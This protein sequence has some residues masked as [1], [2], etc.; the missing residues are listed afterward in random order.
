M[1]TTAIITQNRHDMA[2]IKSISMGKIL[3]KEPAAL[4]D[5]LEAARLPGFFCID[6]DGESTRGLVDDVPE[7]F[8]LVKEYFCQSEP[9]KMKNFNPNY[10]RGYKKY[11]DHESFEIALDDHSNGLSGYPGFLQDHKEPLMAFSEGCHQL[12]MHL[13]SALSDGLM[14]QG[15]DRFENNHR[16]EMPSDSGFKVYCAPTQARLADVTDN[17][18]TDGGTLTLMFIRHLCMQ[19][20]NPLTNEYQWIENRPGQMVVNVANSLQEQS[21]GQ[22]HSC[23]HR[24]TQPEDGV[25][26]RYLLSYFLRPDKVA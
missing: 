16:P 13:L 14:R 15:P 2:S 11:A 1:S 19:L 20:K 8:T 23:L 21:N 12:A 3:A 9:E 5:L 18:H 10:D 22:L 26:E 6:L 7:I 4:S 25:E 17:T 24:V